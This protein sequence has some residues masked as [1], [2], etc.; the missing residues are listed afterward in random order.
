MSSY[1]E[2]KDAVRPIHQITMPRLPRLYAPG[3]TMHVVAPF[4]A[5][6]ERLSTQFHKYGNVFM[7]KKLIFYGMV[8]TRRLQPCQGKAH[9]LSF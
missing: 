8:V 2:R 7:L 3:G 4:S 1:G 9:I 5:E 6:K